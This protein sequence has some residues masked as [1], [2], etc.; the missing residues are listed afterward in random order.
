MK[1]AK[2]KLEIK[3][4]IASIKRELKKTGTAEDTP[5]WREEL[6]NRVARLENHFK[7]KKLSRA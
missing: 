3:I 7:I 1:Q 5:K 4:E 6:E 2:N